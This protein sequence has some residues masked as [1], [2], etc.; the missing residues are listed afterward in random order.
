MRPGIQRLRRRRIG[1]LFIG[2]ATACGL[3]AGLATPAA[4]GEIVAPP[5]L[6][7]LR[8]DPPTAYLTFQDNSDAEQVYFAVLRERDNPDVEVK[9]NLQPTTPVPGVGR[10]V[11]RTY[12]GTVK[13]G[14][15][16][17]ATVEGLAKIESATGVDAGKFTG[18]SNSVC[19]DPAKPATD[20]ALD[21]IEGDEDLMVGWTRNYWV[22]YSN[23]GPA[24][25]GKAVITAAVSGPL[26]IRKLPEN[27]TFNGFTCTA[28]AASGG[29]TGGFR[30]TGG[31]LKQGESGKIPVLVKVAKPGIGAVHTSIGVS[32]GAADKNQGN[33]LSTLNVRAQ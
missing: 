27:T 31:S 23:K 20:L 14:V 12:S 16:Y 30:C 1:Q 22:Y 25:D 13:P 15:A 6:Q 28:T 3:T 8:L 11:T 33:N 19:A 10:V 4:G 7:N 17:C 18:P 32:G 5:R 26:V 2:A 29:A 21:R 9:G 24:I